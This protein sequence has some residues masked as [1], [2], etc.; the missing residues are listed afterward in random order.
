MLSQLA[1]L[2]AISRI[3]QALTFFYPSG[4]SPFLPLCVTYAF[5]LGSYFNNN[6]WELVDTAVLICK[7]KQPSFLQV[8]H[9]SA[10]IVVAYWLTA[11]H[12]SCTFLFAGLNSSIHTVM[13]FYFALASIGVRLPGKSLIT[14]AQIVQVRHPQSGVSM[15]RIIAPCRSAAAPIDSAHFS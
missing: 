8:Y 6:Q 3:P 15:N 9:H 5:A 2:I 1:S 10:T 14:T 12:A 7:R 13:Y 4:A 11:S